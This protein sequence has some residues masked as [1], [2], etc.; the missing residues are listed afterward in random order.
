M[1]R[2]W[3]FLDENDESVTCEQLIQ[4]WVWTHGHWIRK[5]W[6]SD[7]YGLMEIELENLQKTSGRTSPKEQVSFQL[8]RFDA[9]GASLL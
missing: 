8:R 2:D 9:R 1:C 6:F 5:S 3:T 7:G 4:W